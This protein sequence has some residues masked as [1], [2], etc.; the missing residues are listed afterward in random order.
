MDREEKLKA[1]EERIKCIIK[2]SKKK[3]QEMIKK[4]L[5]AQRSSDAANAQRWDA[6]SEIEVA[7]GVGQKILSKERATARSLKVEIKEIVAALG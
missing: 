7:K 6:S 4:L 1:S 5:A 2:K 3:D